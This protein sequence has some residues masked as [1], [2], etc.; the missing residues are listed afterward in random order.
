MGTR[1]DKTCIYCGVDCG[2]RP[3]VKDARGRYACRACAAAAPA[4]V[5]PID[6][7]LPEPSDPPGADA[8]IYALADPTPAA[9]SP[10]PRSCP[11]C[12]AIL[13]PD[14]RICVGCGYDER[15]GVK[16]GA[17][18]GPRCAGCG[19]DMAGLK[20]TKCPE[21]GKRNAPAASGAG[22]RERERQLAAEAARMEYIRPALYLAVGTIGTMLLYIIRGHT[23]ILVAFPVGLS[24]MTAAGVVAFYAMSLFM[25]GFDAPLGLI[26]IR[27]AGIFAL[28][29]LAQSLAALTG[30]PFIAWG[31]RLVVF[32]L[33]VMQEFDI[34]DWREVWAMT[35]IMQVLSF[36]VL[37]GLR[38]LL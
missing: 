19:Y 31:A 3:R 36:A 24:I 8:D 22:R 4:A 26:T 23:S 13:T 20:T 21:C 30:S 2:D 14:A 34:D 15:T 35:I 7:T 10:A 16:I 1:S 18:G 29:E 17:A 38:A 37:V 5:E 9:A 11:G 28:C 27:L 12:G 33:L 25:W 6:L 32:Y